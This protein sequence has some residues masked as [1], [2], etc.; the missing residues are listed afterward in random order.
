MLR[1]A[2][3]ILAT[4]VA[5]TVF[6][7]QPPAAPPPPPPIHIHRAEGAITVDGN[8]DDPGWKNAA[9]IDRFYETS[10]GN[11]VQP[12]A[13]TIVYL[14]YDDR[15]FYIG[16]RCEDPEPSKIRAPYVDRDQVIGTD[17]NIAIL[18]DTRNDKRSAME[19]RVNPRGIQGDAI[20]NDANGN[21]DFSPD[22]FYDT[23]AKI[24]AGGWSAEYRIPFSSLRYNDAPEQTWN[25]LVW[26]NY[27]RDF[28]Y[29]FD[30]APIPRGSNCFIC[31][32]HPIVGL[33]GLPKSGHLTAAPYV[34][35]QS[36]AV[37][38]NGGIVTDGPLEREPLKKDAGL[39]VK[40]T[41][42]QNQALD[43]TFNPD[44]SQ[45]ESDVAQITAN[46][47]FA[48][49][50]PEKRPFFL[51]GFD[52]FDTPIQV[53]YTRTINSPRWGAR[54]TGKIGGSA[55]TVLVTD[56]HG[57]GL[58]I[59]PGPLS[60]SFL[61][62][63]FK[64]YDTIARI[65]HDLG[66]SFAGLVLTDR[67][68]SGG[69]HN[70]VVGPDFQW[71]PNP[72]DA[73]TVELLH[74]DTKDPGSFASG[75]G[76]SSTSHAFFAGWNRTE[77]HYDA[78]V[79]LR[80]IGDGFRADLGFLPQVG[81]REGAVGAG[82]RA[83]PEKGIFRF[84]RTYLAYDLQHD[85]DGNTIFRQWAPG[86]FA[87]G[88]KNLNL[89]VEARPKEQVLVDGKLLDQ[90]Y[91]I[92]FVQ[93]DPHRRWPRITL[94]GRFGQGIDFGSGQVGNQTNFTVA[95]TIRP[96]D[97]ITF[98]VNASREWLDAQ[99]ERVYTATIER[100]KTT[101]SFSARSLVRIIGQYVDNNIT[102]FGHNGSFTGSVLYS[103]KLN[104]QTVLFA[105][106]GDDRFQ[107]QAG[108]LLKADRTLFF[109]V[110]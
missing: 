105:G 32:T 87:I 68:I 18:L 63:D 40:W 85:L 97:K 94:Q 3:A 15:Y 84:F 33:T 37:P 8:L 36:T 49:F 109:K 61:P 106:Y 46:R 108:D 60:S 103:Y 66:A 70:R 93:W 90:T 20:Y 58:T 11:N 55:Y 7:Q 65:R 31:W 17:D 69:G 13:K 23:A 67:E 56:D 4:A 73:V 59:L 26:R 28:R 54:A 75:G 19:L 78:G 1:I 80:D 88:V 45:I 110:S 62:A 102:G 43:M 100:L 12:R 76:S 6:G 38:P 77:Q 9:V 86:I 24:D 50:F 42:T 74:S 98:D 57:G 35:A 14:T 71:R 44:F 25:I 27:P 53:A 92:W 51:E 104:W 5:A 89:N 39:D 72:A 41:P 47:R 34:T 52:L 2:F 99:G 82:Y 22:F 107:N 96:H 30:S 81:Y 29:A 16:I 95:S 21:E 101:Y 10:P 83:Y 64:S 91:A 48:V 79:Q